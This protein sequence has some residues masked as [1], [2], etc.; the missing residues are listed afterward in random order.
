MEQVQ[1]LIREPDVNTPSA[2]RILPLPYQ[3]SQ[4]AFVAAGKLKIRVVE[5]TL[6]VVPRACHEVFAHEYAQMVQ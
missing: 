5:V 6:G 4:P 3:L 1:Y 2:M